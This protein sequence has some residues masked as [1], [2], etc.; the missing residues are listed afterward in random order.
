MGDLNNVIRPC[1]KLKKQCSIMNW[2]VLT[3]S[4]FYNKNVTTQT[5]L[6]EALV[7]KFWNFLHCVCAMVFALYS[8]DNFTKPIE[9]SQMLKH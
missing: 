9:Y 5:S 4:I 2:G 7:L 1:I 3:L 8:T 6:F